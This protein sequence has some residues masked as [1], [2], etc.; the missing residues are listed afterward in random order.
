MRSNKQNRIEHVAV[1]T[2]TRAEYGI[3]KPLLTKIERDPNLELSLLV[4]GLHVLKEFGRTISEIKKDGFKITAEI[5]M[6]PDDLFGNV[7]YHGIG[8]G[9]GVKNFTITLKELQPDILLVFGDRLEALAATLAASTLNIPLGHIHAGDKTDS[10]HI[11]EQIRFSISRFSHL[12]FAPTRRCAERLIKMGEE[13]WRVQNVGALGL[14]GILSIKPIPK[15]ELGK[16]LRVDFDEPV[17]IVLFHPVIHEYKTVGFQMEEIM[18]ALV[19]LDLQSVVIYPTNDLGSE[20]IISVI[21]EYSRVF[22]N[23][24]VFKNLEHEVFVSL[25][26]HAAVMVGNSSSG[27]IEA[28]SLGLPVVNVGSRNVGRE[29]GDNVIFT[30]P[31]KEDII[32]ATKTALYDE[33]FLNVVKKK[34]NPYGDGKTSERILSIVKSVKITDKFLRKKLTY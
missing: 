14:D 13:A 3:L 4:T 32:E 12:L 28:P 27:I 8:L 6:Y 23:F 10:G 5:P 9:E 17:A 25:M 22:D 21:D 19:E 33:N 7:H 15:K 24:R 31:K 30:D 18:K 2:G 26:H 11:D 20:K 34:R 1:V 16:A 29:H